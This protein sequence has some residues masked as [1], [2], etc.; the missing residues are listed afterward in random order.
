M[1][2]ERTE[3]TCCNAAG[4]R[5]G[6][7]P[8][9]TLDDST[10]VS[11]TFSRQYPIVRDEILSAYD[12]DCTKAEKYLNISGSVNPQGRWKNA[13]PLPEEMIDG[14]IAV[15]G[16]GS[17]HPTFDHEVMG[18]HLYA[19]Y[20]TVKVRYKIIPPVKIWPSYL[21]SLIVLALAHR[22]CVPLTE[23][24][25]REDSLRIELYGHANLDGNGGFFARAKAIEARHKP[26][27]SIFSNGD[28]LTRTRF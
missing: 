4:D 23:N 20:E 13:F 5:V 26:T 24:E 21:Y 12:W 14:P 27:K 25:A 17:N 7:D 16:D 18:G 8:I 6:V 19:N 3:I 15:Y 10:P 1:D 11:A 2:A 28:P 22:V 9:E